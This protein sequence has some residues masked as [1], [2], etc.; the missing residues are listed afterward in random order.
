MG[1][2]DV[3]G[4]TPLWTSGSSLVEPVVTARAFS[5]L[6]FSAAGRG[7][8]ELSEP[9]MF[10]RGS[11]VAGVR[12]SLDVVVTLGA[13]GTARAIC[14]LGDAVHRTALAVDVSNRPLVEIMDASG[15]VVARGV[16][17]G[18]ALAEGQRVQ[19]RWVWDSTSAVAGARYVRLQV[20]G[21]D[22]PGSDWAVN[23]TSAWIAFRPQV[24][25]LA[26]GVTVHS[27]F[28]AFNGDV[29]AVQTSNVVHPL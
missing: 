10:P 20:N 21:V 22:V 29:E 19:V 23:P 8:W 1:V 18:A 13:T 16:P 27:P 9:G 17:T 14:Y 6:V 3:T 4:P 25:V 2:P 12:G 28:A 15:F 24:L 5:D 26:G 11:R 7:Q